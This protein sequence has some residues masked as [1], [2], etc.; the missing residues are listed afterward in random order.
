M[1]AKVDL[2]D[3]MPAETFHVLSEMFAHGARV[4]VISWWAAV[5]N[6]AV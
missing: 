2:S 4:L 6:A 3:G 1:D 5:T